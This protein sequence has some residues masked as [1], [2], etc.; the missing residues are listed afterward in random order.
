MKIINDYCIYKI[1]W[2]Y[3]KVSREKEILILSFSGMMMKKI[4]IM[5]IVYKGGILKK[6]IGIIK[7]KN[8]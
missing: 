8:S 7:R 4:L 5:W 2:N 1:V 3:F 6:V